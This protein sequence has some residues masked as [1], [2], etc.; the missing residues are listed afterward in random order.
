VLIA[1]ELTRF[2]LPGCPAIAGI[3]TRGVDRRQIPA[4]LEPCDLCEAE[5]VVREERSW[6]SVAG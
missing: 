4:E 5:A 1:P 6:T 2:H 3:A